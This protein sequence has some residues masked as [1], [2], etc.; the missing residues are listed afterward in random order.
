MDNFQKQAVSPSPK[1][2]E[3]H[4]CQTLRGRPDGSG[5]GGDSARADS[6]VSRGSSDPAG[7]SSA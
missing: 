1:I 6:P 2:F 5:D 3:K 4:S 7:G